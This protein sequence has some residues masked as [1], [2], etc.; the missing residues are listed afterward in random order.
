MT[1]S[2]S[3]SNR[4]S[5]IVMGVQNVAWHVPTWNNRE[6]LRT[7]NDIK[8]LFISQFIDICLKYNSDSGG[9]GLIMWANE[10]VQNLRFDSK[11]ELI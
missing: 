6:N 10:K 11:G 4:Q 8:N 5:V 1:W 7:E 2:T 3:N 9:S